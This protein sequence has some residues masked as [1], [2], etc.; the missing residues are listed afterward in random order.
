M[1]VL[2]FGS[3]GWIGGMLGELLRANKHVV[4]NAASRLED[5]DAVTKELV[6]T[7]PDR[8]VL[9]AGITGRPNVDWC[10]SHK[11]ETY[12]IN[13]TGTVHL[14]QECARL[15][16]HITN[17][18]TGCI[19]EYDETHPIGGPGFTE[20]DSPNFTK[21]F[22]SHTKALAEAQTASLS[23]HLL[24]RVRMPITANGAPRC[25]LTKIA[26][27]PKIVDV[28]NSVTVL[29]TLLPLAVELIES[30]DVGIY[31]FVNPGPVSH[32]ELLHC[33]KQTV[34]PLFEF[35]VMSM[36][37]H[38]KTAVIAKR[39]NNT[40]SADK[41][42]ARFPGKVPSAFDAVRSLYI[43]H[44]PLLR[45]QF[46]PQGVLVTGGAGFI[47]SNFVHHL[48]R[49]GVPCVVFDLL[50]SSASAKHIEG[51]SRVKLVQGDI[52]DESHLGQ[53]L[54]DHPY[55]DS[56]VHFAAETHVDLSYTMSAR[57]TQVN[58][59][60]THRVLEAVRSRMT[61]IRRFVHISTDEVYGETKSDEMQGMAEDRVL[62]P[63]NPYAASKVGAEAM[64]HAYVVSYSLPA[65]IVRA[66]NIFG[67]RQYPE[68]I[69][70][71]FILR[72][73]NQLPLQVQ[74]SGKQTRHFLYVDDACMGVSSVLSYGVPGEVYNIASADELTVLQV[75]EAVQNALG[76]PGKMEYVVDRAF[77]DRRYWVS[78]AK[79]RRL[80]WQP[81]VSFCEGL[82]RTIAYY[83]DNQP[84]LDLIWPSWKEGVAALD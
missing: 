15:G 14:V 1:R 17:F 50:T 57:F 81:K 42:C 63:T 68:K 70:P 74:G 24:L 9:A 47:G 54:D 18:A 30:G 65:V 82:R 12:R 46:L 11:E 59:L 37:D 72:S 75:A 21:S 44:R 67:P 49:C 83:R 71:R 43:A 10:E 34:D 2:S 76:V 32:G 66:N 80:F 16:I 33:Y 61:R 26:N 41:L 45:R 29:P 77:N 51:L 69:I 7:H 5:F 73:M 64:V 28:P 52:L 22:Y 27:Y 23:G 31:N 35:H 38:D 78:D 60:G 19:F 25:F 48:H 36:D 8:V 20:T 13:V 58:T 84:G 55:V 4:I 79:L 62:L 39:S 56:V 53:V 40:L 3:T 6:E